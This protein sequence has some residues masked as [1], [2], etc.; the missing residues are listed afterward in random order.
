MPRR[1]ADKAAREI[2]FFINKPLLDL[3]DRAIFTA[4]VFCF[5]IDYLLNRLRAVPL[6]R[7]QNVRQLMMD[8]HTALTLQASYDELHVAAFRVN[9]SPLS[10]ADHRQFV[11][12]ARTKRFFFA[13]D[14]KSPFSSLNSTV[15]SATI[16]IQ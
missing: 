2:L 5:L 15:K 6:V 9:I 4:Y 8:F 10:A 7:Y 16:T 3:S 11:I 14:I 13:P 1:Y 12:T